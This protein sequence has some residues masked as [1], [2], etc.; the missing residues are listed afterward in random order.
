MVMVEV[1]LWPNDVLP[2]GQGSHPTAGLDAS[3]AVS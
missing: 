2:S 3:I 1:D